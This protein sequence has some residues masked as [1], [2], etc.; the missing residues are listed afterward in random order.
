MV[1]SEPEADPEIINDRIDR[2]GTMP[3]YVF[4]GVAYTDP[5]SLVTAFSENWKEGKKQLFRGKV[6]EH[7]KKYN[8]DLGKLCLAAEEEASMTGGKDDMIFWRLLYK[9]NP[10]LKTF[11]WK[12]KT[13]ESLAA[14]GREM[15]DM[16]WAKDKRHYAYYAG[17]LSEKLLT[18]YAIMT[19]PENENLK[20]VAAEAEDSYRLDAEG[21]TDTGRTFY[22]AAY[23]LSGQKLLYLS[24]RHL[25]TIG[26]LV[27]YLRSLLDSS[28]ESFQKICR[29]LVDSDGVL[30]AQ[31]ETWLI[32]LGK[33]RELDNWRASMNS[34]SR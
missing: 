5:A 3:P 18:E 1:S 8:P 14:L 22:M 30:D 16:L 23:L 13:Y 17:I 10:S 19:A 24:G 9:I 31:L 20:R 26:E 15:L 28:F 6:Y 12:G 2:K 32:A 33:R 4:L 25:R 27:D 34:K 11:C 29:E 21:K 7:F